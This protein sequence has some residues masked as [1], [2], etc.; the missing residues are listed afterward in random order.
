MSAYAPGSK[1]SC[2]AGAMGMGGHRG[3]NLQRQRQRIAALAGGDPRL[4]ARA[5]RIEK[6]LDLQPQRLARRDP[7]LAKREPGAGP[8]GE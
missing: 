2:K 7:G 5:N 4:A 8:A 1:K 6:R 3:L